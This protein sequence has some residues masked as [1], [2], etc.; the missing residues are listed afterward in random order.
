M[1]FFPRNPTFFRSHWTRFTRVYCDVIWTFKSFLPADRL[2]EVFFRRGFKAMVWERTPRCRTKY[3]FHVLTWKSARL[4]TYPDLWR[5]QANPHA[6]QF[7]SDHQA[8]KDK[9][10]EWAS[11]TRCPFIVGWPPRPWKYP[12]Y[13]AIIIDH[14]GGTSRAAFPV[15]LERLKTDEILD[16]KFYPALGRDDNSA[17]V[18]QRRDV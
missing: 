14:S 18:P 6:F 10:N 11:L 3:I 12:G 1:Y 4:Q 9:N 2:H 13:A 17:E 15:S 7:H 16:D 8:S 5:N